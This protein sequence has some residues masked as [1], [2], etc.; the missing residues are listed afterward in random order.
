M[1][2]SQHKTRLV[3]GGL[4]GSTMLA[5]DANIVNH[6]AENTTPFSKAVC[7]LGNRGYNVGSKKSWQC[8]APDKGGFVLPSFYL[9]AQNGRVG[10]QSLG[11]WARSNPPDCPRQ[12]RAPPPLTGGYQSKN[13]GGQHG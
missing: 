12:F 4:S 10:A 2:H 9:Y 3:T 8:P 1:T 5:N 6:F 11:V 7:V 13:R